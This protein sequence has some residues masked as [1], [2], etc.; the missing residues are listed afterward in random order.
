MGRKPT[1]KQ[2]EQGAHSIYYEIWMLEES[3]NWISKAAAG[4]AAGEHS[5]D[6]QVSLNIGLESFAIH[7]RNLIEFFS[8]KRDLKP[9]FYTVGAFPIAT[10]DFTGVGNW[11][12]MN[13][14]IAHIGKTRGEESKLGEYGE[15]EQIKCALD[16]RI[17]LFYD[18]L[19]SE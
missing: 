10:V 14:Q 2:I 7:A 13:N 6:L 12:K 19:S 3:Y 11:E 9:D 16:A 8:G 1:Q 17:R 5:N 18:N 4:M 15:W